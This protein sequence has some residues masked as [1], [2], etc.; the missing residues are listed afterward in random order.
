MTTLEL[1]RSLACGDAARVDEIYRKLLLF[2]IDYTE[3]SGEPDRAYE[4]NF[5]FAHGYYWLPC[6][7]CGR[8]YSGREGGDVAVIWSNYQGVGGTSH[9]VCSSPACAAEAERINNLFPDGISPETLNRKPGVVFS[10]AP[11]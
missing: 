5:A 3:G 6:F 9:V 1:A 8:W 2:L 7:L 4:R 10:H 11:A